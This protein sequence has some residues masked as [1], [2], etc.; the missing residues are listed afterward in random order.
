MFAIFMQLSW[1][2]TVFFLS[3]Q[4]LDPAEELLTAARKLQEKETGTN[5]PTTVSYGFNLLFYYVSHNLSQYDYDICLPNT[6]FNTI[7][8]IGE[9]TSI[10][11]SQMS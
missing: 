7:T 2:I 10:F 1:I 8:A 9:L 3:L 11:T 5:I 4:D 6:L